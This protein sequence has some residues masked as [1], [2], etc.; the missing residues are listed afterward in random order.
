MQV[1]DLIVSG[2]VR[3]VG[4]LKAKNL[5]DKAPMYSY[6]TTDL[7]PNSSPLESGRLYFV[8]E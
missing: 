6:G 7:T 4:E 5:D 2:D 8:Y 1:K 3:I